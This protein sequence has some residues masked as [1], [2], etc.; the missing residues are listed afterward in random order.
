MIFASLL[1]IIFYSSSGF[2]SSCFAPFSYEGFSGNAK[3]IFS[4]KVL[5][6]DFKYYVKVDK[7]WFPI[8][9]KIEIDPLLPSEKME[10]DSGMAYNIDIRTGDWIFIMSLQDS[11]EL[12]YIPNCGTMVRIVNK[13]S[14]KFKEEKKIIE[15]EILRHVVK[16]IGPPKYFPNKK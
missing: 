4:G 7:S 13:N 10:T 1:S 3:T 8:R 12:L 11:N 5:F 16:K 9:K 6:E 15:E 2:T 14:K